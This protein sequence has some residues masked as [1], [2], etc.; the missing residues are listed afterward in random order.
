[1]K[2]VSRLT[3]EQRGQLQQIMREDSRARVRRRA[4]TILL[5]DQ[6]YTRQTI[7]DIYQTKADT[8]SDSIDAWEAYG[9]EGLYDAPRSGRP[10]ALNDAEQAR[11]IELI[12]ETPRQIKRVIHQLV[13]DVGKTVS[14]S[15]L[16]RLIDGAKGRWKRG[17]RSLQSKRDPEEFAQGKREVEALRQRQ[18]RH[19]IEL[20]FFD[21]S[22]FSLEPSIPYAYQFPGEEL[23]IP[24]SKSARL[25]VLGFLSPDM[26]F[27]SFV[28]ECSINSD[29]VIACF[30]YVSE[31]ITQETWVVVDNASM[32]TSDAFEDRITQWEAKGLFVYRLPAYSPELNLIEIIWRFMKYFWLPVSA[33]AS[34]D[35]LV[36]AVEE[37]LRKIGTEEFCIQFAEIFPKEIP[38]S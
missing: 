3:E 19:E 6:G 32:H 34:F 18:Q 17:R 8:V 23:E 13:E 37:I 31:R 4:H 30:D 26:A 14:R 27:H 25:N 24:S 28:F 5:S 9:V 36:Q 29:V 2:F 38:A 1:M 7:A 15:T 33:Y 21:E 35:A 10:T 11:A 12:K 16:K 20:F 22:G